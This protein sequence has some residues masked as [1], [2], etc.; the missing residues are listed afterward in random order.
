MMAPSDTCR[1][2]TQLTAEQCAVMGST[3]VLE[4]GITG[5]GTYLDKNSGV[6]Q[7]M[8][9][10]AE[11]IYH[12]DGE[13]HCGEAMELKRSHKICKDVNGRK[14]RGNNKQGDN[15]RE[16]SNGRYRDIRVGKDHQSPR[17]EAWRVGSGIGSDR[18]E[19]MTNTS[20]WE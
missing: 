11:E 16:S 17:L 10:A 6:N 18:T 8:S 19:T 15:S 7:F 9:T 3:R 4:E 20:P 1:R 5:R 12:A 2:D 13:T 14:S